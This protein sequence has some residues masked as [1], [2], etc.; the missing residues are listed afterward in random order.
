MA[1][2]MYF[3]YAVYA[4]KINNALEALAAGEVVGTGF[5]AFFLLV[6]WALGDIILGLL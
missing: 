4:D 1:F 5:G 2:A 6:L 3:G